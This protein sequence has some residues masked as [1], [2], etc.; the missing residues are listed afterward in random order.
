MTTMTGMTQNLS[1]LINTPTR[2][3][4]RSQSILDLIITDSPALVQESGTWPPISTCDHEI[5]YSRFSFILPKK[6]FLYK[7]SVVL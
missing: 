4:E 3:N 1:Q 6:T 2:I 5:V 7:D